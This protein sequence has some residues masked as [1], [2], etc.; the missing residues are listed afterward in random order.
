MRTEKGKRDIIALFAVK[1]VIWVYLIEV[2]AP[3]N[4]KWSEEQQIYAKRF[5]YQNNVIYEVVN[6]PAQIDKTLEDITKRT[7]DIL[8]G[9]T[10]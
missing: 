1:D 5:A 2:K 6:N 3:K 10:L 9:I 7:D 8:K 4:W